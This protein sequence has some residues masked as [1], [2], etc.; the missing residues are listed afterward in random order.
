MLGQD[1]PSPRIAG[2]FGG[3]RFD[4]P[5]GFGDD[6]SRSFIKHAYPDRISS[7]LLLL[8]SPSDHTASDRT[9]SY[10]TPASS[11]PFHIPS[12]PISSHLIPSHP[13]SS[14]DLI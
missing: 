10:P 11:H 12:H 1:R 14:R 4:G 13:I 6:M 5:L 3:K 7:R 8:S 2:S 9:S